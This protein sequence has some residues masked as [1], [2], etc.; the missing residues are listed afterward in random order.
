MYIG[1]EFVRAFRELR[2]HFWCGFE[3][4]FFG[5]GGGGRMSGFSNWGLL[6]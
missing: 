5:G 1:T 3:V 2:G 6:G 4:F